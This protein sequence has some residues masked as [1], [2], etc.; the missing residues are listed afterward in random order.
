MCAAGVV[1]S[2]TCAASRPRGMKLALGTVQFGIDYGAFNAQGKTPLSE[3]R[4]IL[5]RAKAAGI[6]TLDTA[7]A[8]GEAEAV[9]ATAKA[10]GEFDIIT[11]CPALVN[12]DDTAA[13]AVEAAAGP[14]SRAAAAACGPAARAGA[15]AAALCGRREASSAAA[16]AAS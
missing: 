10:P 13:A 9:L 7:R 1:A 8:Y 12:D 11:K 6:A 5:A 16:S 14:G 3:V 2:I 4:A 15:A